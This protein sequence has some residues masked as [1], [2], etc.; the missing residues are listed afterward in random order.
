M[1]SIYK[2]GI[3][4]F[5]IF[6][7]GISFV[8]FTK[9]TGAANSVGKDGHIYS[10][11]K[12][13]MSSYMETDG[14]DT[15]GIIAPGAALTLISSQF[16]FTEGP[17][18]DQYGNVFF[19]DQPNDKIWKY[20]YDGKLSV[21]LDKTGR[22]NGMYFT[23]KGKL[24]AC[25]DER[26]ELWS[27]NPDGTH[28]VI[29]KEYNGKRLNGPN[30]LWVDAKGNIYFTDPYYE[31]PYWEKNVQ[32]VN[33]EHVYFLPKGKMEPVKVDDS[34]QKPNG[35]IGTPDNKH[36]Y[37][38]DI[39]GNKTYKYTISPDGRL[40]NKQL[41]VEQGSDGMTIDNKG[42]IYITGNGITVYNP[43]GQK[44]E[45]IDVPEK[46]TANVCFG[47]KE[48]DQLFITASKSVYILSMQ[49]K[50]VQ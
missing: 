21:F 40:T 20:S 26:N 14:K 28:T 48:K 19:T 8:A 50:G 5:F 7:A 37:V 13:I 17:A 10:K 15:G 36:L 42:N 1:N 49:V 41:F 3:R 25:A 47:G 31:R 39:Q 44:I 12:L 35:I 27:F 4:C 9:E 6:L 16:S 2:T 38:A 32:R 34:L 43:Q 46:W 23:K 11:S 30:D 24:I 45:H 22:S 33:G 29:M 18:A